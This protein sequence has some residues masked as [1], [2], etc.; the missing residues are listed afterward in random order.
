MGEKATT[1][2]SAVWEY[3]HG[4]EMREWNKGKRIFMDIHGFG[5]PYYHVHPYKQAAVKHIVDNVPNWITYVIIFGS[6]VK[7]WHMWWKDLDVCIVGEGADHLLGYRKN[8]IL[9]DC[10]MDFL[11]YNSLTILSEHGAKWSDVRYH[12]CREG[13]MVYEKAKSATTSGI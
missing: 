1:K 8:F 12:I 9:P 13:V 11:E 10:S 3:E 4:M 7:N 5:Y 2:C 6:A